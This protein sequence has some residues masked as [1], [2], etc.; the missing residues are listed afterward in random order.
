MFGGGCH[1][2]IIQIT[3][4]AMPVQIAAALIAMVGV[5]LSVLVSYLTSRQQ[6]RL[7]AQKLREEANRIFGGRLYDRR[8]EVYPTLFK[9]LSNFIKLLYWGNVDQSAVR[10]LFE[11]LQEWDSSYSIYMT[12]RTHLVFR[13]VRHA[14]GD[15]CSASGSELRET[16]C[17][18]DAKM[19][20]KE[21]LQE[22][23]LALKHELGIHAFLDPTHVDPDKSS[24]DY[25]RDY[26]K[27]PLPGPSK[28][29]SVESPNRRSS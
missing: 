6:S 21:R 26:K 2:A 13:D 22:V 28:S 29:A 12:T 11:R 4:A 5:A 3:G 20:F 19:R 25:D 27:I 14:V 24:S 7:E 23:E 16:F 9:H 15:L 8:I 1:S 17:S 18:D 10:G